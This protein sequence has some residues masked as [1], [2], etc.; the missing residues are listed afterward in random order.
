MQ[1]YRDWGD[2]EL[3]CYKCGAKIVEGAIF[4]Y[5]CGQ[6]IIGIPNDLKK[7]STNIDTDC[8]NEELKNN[9]LNLKDK[10][11]KDSS[12]SSLK[13]KVFWINGNKVVFDEDYCCY[14]ELRCQYEKK[15][16]DLQEKMLKKLESN[17]QKGNFEK[18]INMVP[19]EIEKNFNECLDKGVKDLFDN[20][21]D[22]ID[23]DAIKNEI[24]QAFD[25]DRALNPFVNGINKITEKI[26]YYDT[27]RKMRQEYRSNKWVGGGF[28][29]SGAIK[30]SINAKLLNIGSA[31]LGGIYE[32]VASISSNA[33]I[34]SLKDD[35][36]C[37]KKVWDCV[38]GTVNALC[39][40]VLFV[41]SSYLG[42]EYQT[43]ETD[44]EIGLA[45]AK[46]Y[47]KMWKNKSLN[48][49]EAIK[50]IVRCI[51][52]NPWEILYY[53]EIYEINPK[54]SNEMIELCKYLGI[55]RVV[56]KRLIR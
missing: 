24:L 1:I 9:K 46:N 11:L 10:K 28:G 20:G 38:L 4:C 44:D 13:T 33:D 2:S 6:K 43:I 54:T 51:Q 32:G 29:I 27:G 26:E 8:S 14:V 23:E 18:F 41:V 47:L 17:S 3:F 22:Y 19:E 5:K 30:G 12:K 52:E 15:A 55:D 49:S 37:D 53:E 25:V 42:Y 50:S 36:I 48:K 34:S 7:E 35:F 45:R 40:G 21:I 31:A 16:I 56:R 39:H